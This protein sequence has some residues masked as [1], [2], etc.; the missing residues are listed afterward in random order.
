[1]PEA[2]PRGFPPEEFAGRLARAQVRMAAA[3]LDAL[4]LTTEPEV[5]YFSGFLTQFWESPT[6]PWFLLVPAAGKPVAVI[7]AIGAECM[8]RSWIEDIRSWASPNPADEG[9]S[10]L[11]EAVRELV[12]PAPRIGLPKGPETHL[13]Q[14]LGDF[15]RLQAALPEARWGDD[16][17]IMRAL[18]MVKSEAEIAKIA[19]VCD[20]V[21]GVF[22][23]LPNFVQAGMTEAAVFRRFKIACLEAGAD[24]V[25]YLVGG[26]APGGVGDIISPPRDR[27]LAEG[28]VLMLDTG[29]VFDGYFC[30]FDRNYALGAV[31]ASADHAYRTAFEATEAGFAAARPGATAADVFHAMADVIA[32]AGG[33]D[34][35][36]GRMG[37]GLG[38]QLTE[39]PSNAAW[40]E[41]VLEPGMVLTLEPG[42]A[43]G[44]G[45]VM[46]HE[47]NLVIRED[48]PRYLTRRAPET[49]PRIGR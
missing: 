20:I 30:D 1:M 12:G 23:D 28:D 48:G 33:G 31:D 46:V 16:A 14:P 13:R 3:G 4:L 40:D 10:L 21:S 19:H 45:R 7:P 34:G 49:M 15:E 8:A 37:H 18:R 6:R 9:V 47:E 43:I 36:V 2:P 35:G 17:G 42:L 44:P 22:E 11:A 26:A 5:R 24:D 41:T 39:W 32:R 38:M 29:A 25:R 27:P